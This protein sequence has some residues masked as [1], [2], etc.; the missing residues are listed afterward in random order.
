MDGLLTAVKTVKQNAEPSLTTVQ[1]SSGKYSRAKPTLDLDDELAPNQI[2]DLLKSRPS[3]EELTAALTILDPYSKARKL[4]HDI[5]VP[6]PDT[7][8][9][10]QVLVSTTVPDH[11]ALLSDERKSRD[12]KLS[13]TLLRCFSSV[14]GLEALVSHLRLLV[15]SAGNSSQQAEGSRNHSVI[16]DLLAVIAALL[17]PSDFLFRLR[18]DIEALYQNQARQ[19]IAWNELVSLIA[20]GKII[21]VAAEAFT[22]LSGSST[23]SSITWISEGRHYAPWLGRNI[24]LFISRL[25]ASDKAGWIS[26]ASLAERSLSL[27]YSCGYTIPWQSNFADEYR[28]ISS[29]GY[30]LARSF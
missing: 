30:L 19:H 13:S 3:H 18:K 8:Q 27:G 9:I 29:T 15:A 25:D 16:R 5:R 14:P 22:C 21:S 1:S 26:V 10:L 23:D 11:W 20:S 4:N 6:G 24:S 2:I 7:T 12:V 28:S 17:E